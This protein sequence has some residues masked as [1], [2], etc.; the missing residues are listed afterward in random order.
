MKK[1]GIRERRKAEELG[2]VRR[3]KVRDT[4]G[5]LQVNTNTEIKKG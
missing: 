1:R 4:I 3:G 2:G 5:H